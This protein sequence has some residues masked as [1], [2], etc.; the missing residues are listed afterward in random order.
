M[1]F[2]P[3][4]V[5]DIKFSIMYVLS[6]LSSSISPLIVSNL[7]FLEYISYTSISPFVVL[8]DDSIPR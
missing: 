5:F 2:S 1:S 3:F 7:T 8:N 4:I 6:I